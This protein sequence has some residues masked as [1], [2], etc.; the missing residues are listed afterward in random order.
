VGP[1]AGRAASP[2][3]HKSD[4]PLSDF[5]ERAY[6]VALAAA[7]IAAR[8]SASLS[9][10]GAGRGIPRLCDCGPLRAFGGRGGLRV[11][12]LCRLAARPLRR[13]L[14]GIFGV[15]LEPQ[16]IGAEVE[17]AGHSRLRPPSPMRV[18]AKNAGS[19]NA[20]KTPLPT[21][22]R[23]L[24]TVVSPFAHV[25]ATVWLAGSGTAA[26]MMLSSTFGIA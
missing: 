20:V 2:R 18:C 15:R 10:H 16:R 22:W 25:W 13:L 7:T 8:Y 26:V 6:P 23:K 3:L 11:R 19:A 12:V 5:V 4:E 21:R 9:R 1:S 17:F 24:L 14:G